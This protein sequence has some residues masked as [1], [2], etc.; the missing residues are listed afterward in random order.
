MQLI[1]QDKDDKTLCFLDTSECLI[2][3]RE[4]KKNGFHV[5]TLKIS[6]NNDK[7][8]Y[9][10]PDNH[11]L[12][13]NENQNKWYEFELKGIKKT[14]T[15]VKV[16]CE[17]S[18]YDTLSSFVPS[19]DVTGRTVENG[20]QEILDNAV[21][22]SRWLAGNSDIQ[23][24]FYMQRTRRSLKEVLSG[25]VNAVDGVLS[26]RIEVVNGQIYR[27]IDILSSVGSDRGKVIYDDREITQIDIDLPEKT[28]Y[29]MAYGYG[30]SAG[31]DENGKAMLTTFKN[32]VWSTTKGDPVN[33]PA[34]QEWVALPEE[35]L[36]IYGIRDH[37]GEMQH[38]CTQ[39]VESG[40][41]IAENLLERTYAGLLQNVEDSTNY[42][43]K[44]YDIEKLGYNR[45]EIREGDRIGVV[46]TALGLKLKA[47][48]VRYKEDYLDPTANDFE[49]AN[50]NKTIVENMLEQEQQIS[51][52][53]D[54]VDA[55][56]KD[57]FVRSV[58]KDW[59]NEIAA[60]SGFLLYGD[61]KDGLVCLNAK[62]HAA[63]TKATRLKGGSIQV[64]NSKVDGDWVWST[65]ITGDGMIADAIYTGK[66][67]GDRMEIDLDSSTIL[68]GDRNEAG[69]IDA[70]QL[71]YR[72]GRLRIGD[73]NDYLRILNGTLEL[74]KE[75]EAQG[76]EVKHN[77]IAFTTN[78]YADF[79]F[80][81]KSLEGSTGIFRDKVQVGHFAF[82]NEL[83]GML[84]L[85]K[86]R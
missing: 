3:T 25:W 24:N 46:I 66:I 26:E 29:T 20:L 2:A 74:G 67:S 54:Q 75:D 1:I 68:L 58:L 17:S 11:L 27:Y 15:N 70:P 18:Y 28:T 60:E 83:S 50:F 39:W 13:F 80:E 21:P 63:A 5:F 12:Y 9:I 22:K 62:E 72:G 78:G 84:N 30:K 81:H 14:A 47:E 82:V 76:V 38:R 4:W 35:Y 6:L 59:N 42:S 41:E 43:I 44:A 86:V 57:I 36:E 19:V 56:V 37:Q 40:V 73:Y 52:I 64:S 32:V 49:L 8:K 16:A 45:Q 48:I 10:I 61:P 85:K 51:E 71:E 65:V 23:G 31:M 33:K 79:V 34:G 55:V 7:T 69:I 53:K 77:R